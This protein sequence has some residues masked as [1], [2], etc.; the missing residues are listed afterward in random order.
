MRPLLRPLQQGLSSFREHIFLRNGVYYFR[1]DVPADLLQYFPA[2]EVKRSLKTRDA[3]IAKIAAN[4]LELRVQ[5]AYA[6]L[7][8]GLLSDDMVKQL[9]DSVM[10]V[11]RKASFLAKKGSLLESMISAYTAEKQSGWSEKTKVEVAGI[12]RLLLDVVGNV[13][14]LSVT[15]PMLIE[16][17][18]TLLEIPPNVYK[19]YPHKTIREVIA[20]ASE[21]GMS[22]KSVNKHVARLGSLLKYCNDIGVLPNNPASG[23]KISEKLRADQERSVYV[24]EDIAKIINSLPVNVDVPERYW[25]P[26]I[27]LYTG[28]R[29]NE[30]CQLYVEDVI[31][32]DGC[33]CF[34]VNA[35][36]DKRLK[37]AASVRVIP[38]HQ[39]LIDAGL[40]NYVESVKK[41]GH[42][43]LWM[44]LKWARVAGYTNS[45][46]KWYQR[47]NRHYVTD[48]PKKVFHSMRHTV[49]D[50]LKQ[51]GI[52]E[53]VIAELLGHTH[54]SI[55]SGRYGKRYQP[56]VLL[57][58]LMQLDYGVDIRP[59][60]Y[61]VV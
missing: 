16:L 42:S 61:E 12:F 24:A 26:L 55:T 59:W 22:I 29:L 60:D 5:Q 30:I 45:I 21:S 49:A 39:K 11:T 57:D 58:A 46:C 37:N 54:A 14:V 15:R 8:A 52:S 6:M 13:D 47:F 48:D 53:V 4:A 28:L 43:R 36:K 32:L 38:V 10:P 41:V 56:K 9:V 1:L 18:S 7:R 3:E 19:K 51:K 35:E 31:M 27:G 50:T 40:V 2:T 25:I 44:N 17:R 34:D 20:S 23:L 33:W